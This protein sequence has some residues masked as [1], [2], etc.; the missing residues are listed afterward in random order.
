ML[1]HFNR[2]FINRCDLFMWLFIIFI[3][4]FVLI[5]KKS[6]QALKRAYEV[7][8]GRKVKALL[9]SLGMGMSLLALVSSFIA[10]SE[11]KENEAKP[12]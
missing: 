9:A 5:F 1:C 7:P 6:N 10:P 11:L 2:H 8:G 12:T 3:G 4:Y